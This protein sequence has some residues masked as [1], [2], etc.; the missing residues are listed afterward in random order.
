MPLTENKYAALL[1]CSCNSVRKSARKIT[2]HYEDAL[3][4][5]GIRQPQF[6]ILAALA[7]TGPVPITHLASALMLERTGLTRNLTILERN[8]WVKTEIGADDFRQRVVSLSQKGFA[9]LDQAIPYWEKAQSAFQHQIGHEKVAA[10]E[11]SLH[12]LREN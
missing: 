12:K 2:Q 7:N 9:K 6:S 10:V 8:G 5:V 3:R 1:D 4:E 11:R